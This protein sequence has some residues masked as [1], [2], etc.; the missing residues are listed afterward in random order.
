MLIDN[1]KNNKLGEVL[2]ENIDNNCKLSI[3]SGY[4]TL[5]GFSHLKTELEKVEGILSICINNLYDEKSDKINVAYVLEMTNDKLSLIK[6]EFDN[7][8]QLK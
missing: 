7:I 8:T 5:Y 3:I 6:Q 2:K 4:F 1:K